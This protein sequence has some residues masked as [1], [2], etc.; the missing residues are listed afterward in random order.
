MVAIVLKNENVSG[1]IGSGNDNA[2]AP[3]YPLQN[4]TTFTSLYEENIY[5]FIVMNFLASVANDVELEEHKVT[6]KANNG[7]SF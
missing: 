4:K 3:I 2:H 7:Y 5:D 1:R 6:I